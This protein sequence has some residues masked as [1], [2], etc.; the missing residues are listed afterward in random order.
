MCVWALTK[1][2][3]VRL[4]VVIADPPILARSARPSGCI[5]RRGPAPG[6]PGRAR[7]L[8]P[9]TIRLPGPAAHPGACGPTGRGPP[10]GCR[11]AE[12]HGNP[13]AA[14]P[15]NREPRARRRPGARPARRPAP[16]GLVRAA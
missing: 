2:G 5:A 4:G 1:P 3:T 16:A 7:I 12:A 8:E 15:A 14:T 11:D 13:I 10:L 6:P 9:R